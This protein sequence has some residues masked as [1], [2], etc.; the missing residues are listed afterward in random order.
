VRHPAAHRPAGWIELDLVHVAPTPI[1]AR[2]E[3]PDDRVSGLTKMCGRVLV[4]GAVAAA[5]MP[6]GHAEAQVHPLVADLKAILTTVPA[7]RDFVD[8]IEMFAGSHSK[9]QPTT[10]P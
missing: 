3:R 6:A 8:L 1:L 5:H 4:L 9:E 2:L 7:S 10:K